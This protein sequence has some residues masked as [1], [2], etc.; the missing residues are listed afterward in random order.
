MPNFY[1]QFVDSLNRLY[2]FLQQEV[3]G[4]NV[5]F[6]SQNASCPQTINFVFMNNT[7]CPGYYLVWLY[8]SLMLC[9]LI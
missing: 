4:V 6:F 5:Y 3:F 7:V 2:F 9:I 8:A 1:Y